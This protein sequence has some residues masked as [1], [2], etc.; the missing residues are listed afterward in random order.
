MTDL[1]TLRSSQNVD[2]W[3]FE[4]C[5]KVSI[6]IGGVEE[7]EDANKLMS[8]NDIGVLG[9]HVTKELADFI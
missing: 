5:G 9:L 1:T 3:Q 8:P 6:W 4:W 7:A 2:K